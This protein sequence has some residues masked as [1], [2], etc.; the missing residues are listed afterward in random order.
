MD[1]ATVIVSV[2]S[3]VATAAS[4]TVI[5]RN[6]MRAQRDLAVD[7][8]RIERENEL[9]GVL[10]DA[11]LALLRAHEAL[12]AAEAAVHQPPRYEDEDKHDLHEQE[13][14]ESARYWVEPRLVDLAR[15]LRDLTVVEARL[16]IRLGTTHELHGIVRHTRHVIDGHG[17]R[18]LLELRWG[19][20]P[21][22]RMP[23]GEPL[24]A[25]ITYAIQTS[26]DQQVRFFDAAAA[27]I[28][29]DAVTSS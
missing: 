7:G 3:V 16:A 23:L 22:S 5:A 12:V 27:R 10:D 19:G 25:M 24:G 8:A 21:T 6:S 29:P 20:D 1:L 14:A 26:R 4:A 2:T 13:M 15:A 28:G 17:H 18:P 11:A 9:R